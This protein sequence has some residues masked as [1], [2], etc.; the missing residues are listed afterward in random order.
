ME[1]RLRFFKIL[2][3]ITIF[4]DAALSSLGFY[5]LTKY[6][7]QFR[8]DAG[9]LVLL[10]SL[11]FFMI[12]AVFVLFLLKKYPSQPISNT[13]EGFVFTFAV[14]TFLCSLVD[15]SLIY[16]FLDIAIDLRK[17]SNNLVTT[18]LLFISISSV[19]TVAAAVF[20][21]ITSFR[22]LRIIKRNRWNLAQE[23]KNIG[24]DYE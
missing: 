12:S 23:I 17:K 20:I 2:L 11:V 8:D 3:L 9:I 5:L 4:F 19:I 21:S 6:V 10:S 15:L 14:I 16:L 7:P 13:A 24:T 1:S 18:T 22:L